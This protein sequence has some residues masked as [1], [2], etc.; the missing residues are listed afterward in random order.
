MFYLAG[1]GILRVLWLPLID[2]S[3]AILDLVPMTYMPFLII[4]WMLGYHGHRI[5][6]SIALLIVF[7]GL[8]IFSIGVT[9]WLYGRFSGYKLIDF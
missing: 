5:L 1:L 6:L 7:I 8:L 2:I 4:G 3:P 9:T